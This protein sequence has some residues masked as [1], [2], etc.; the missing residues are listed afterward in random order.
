VSFVASDSFVALESLV[1]SESILRDFSADSADGNE[2]VGTVEA[3]GGSAAVVGA[4][5]VPSDPGLARSRAGAQLHTV[6]CQ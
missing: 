4:A 6:R 1:A 3:T 2:G 5:H